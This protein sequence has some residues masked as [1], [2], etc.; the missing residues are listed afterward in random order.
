MVLRKTQPLLLL[1]EIARAP[2]CSC[3]LSDAGYNITKYSVL[4]GSINFDLGWVPDLV[5]KTSVR[6]RREAPE[7]V[8]S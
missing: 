5:D 2:L 8:V 6:H 7:N 3:F 4:F 1:G